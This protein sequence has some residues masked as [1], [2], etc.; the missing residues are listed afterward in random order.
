MKSTDFIKES[1]VQEIE[2]IPA[3]RYTGGKGSM[4]YGEKPKQFFP[5]PGGSGLVYSVT[6]LPNAII[7]IYDPKNPASE[8]TMPMVIGQLELSRERFPVEG[9]IALHVDTI[10]VDE[11]YRGMS[12]SKSLYGIALSVLKKPLVAGDSQTPGGRRNWVSLHNIPGVQ[13]YGYVALDDDELDDDNA[14]QYIDTI[15]GKLG[16]DYM[17]EVSGQ[18]F[19]R[20]NV[21]PTTTGKELTNYVKNK[22]VNIYG[23]MWDLAQGGLYAIWTGR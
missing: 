21:K 9:G 7:K 14:D 12:I 19:F 22:S 20:F 2:R 17:G 5:L 11:D 16:G 23:D 10:T 18:R 1:I 3:D 6:N 15:M 13:V 4:Y 8:K